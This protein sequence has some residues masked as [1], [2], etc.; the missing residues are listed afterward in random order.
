MPVVPASD[1][2]AA[3]PATPVRA[4][5]LAG[6]N[7]THRVLARGAELR[8]TDLACDACAHL[9]LYLD[10]RP[11]ERLNTADTVKV[12]WNACL[13]DGTSVP[14][15]LC[16]PYALRDATDITAHGGRRAYLDR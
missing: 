15:F 5:T 9:L 10:G 1:W 6:G 3:A 8:L 14:G 2:P 11:W 16:E 7:Y 13:A 12:Q 4:E